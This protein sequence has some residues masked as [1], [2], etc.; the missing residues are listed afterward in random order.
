MQLI[1][2]RRLKAHIANGKRKIYIHSWTHWQKF[3]WVFKK[4]IPHNYIAHRQLSTIFASLV[5]ATERV[6]THN[7][8]KMAA[9]A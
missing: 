7:I 8:Y 1:I 4:F 6:H 9:F 2:E 5:R 3:E